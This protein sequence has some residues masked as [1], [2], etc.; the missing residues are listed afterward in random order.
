MK[1]NKILE[2]KFLIIPF[3]IFMFLLLVFENLYVFLVWF[4]LLLLLY[5]F[6]AFRYKN[7]SF[8]TL[9]VFTASLV[10]SAYIYFVFSIYHKYD[11][12]QK[13]F[14]TKKF[15]IN[16]KLVWDRYVWKDEFWNYFILKNLAKNYEIWEKLKIYGMLYPVE[17]EQKSYKDFLTKRFL[18]TNISFEKLKNIFQFDYKNYLLMKDILW[19][20][21]SK[22]EFV[23]WKEKLS[24][25][26][27]LRQDLVKKY[28]YIYSWYDDKY[29]ALSLGLLIWDKSYLDKKLYDDFIHSGLVHIIVVS[30]WN[31]MFLII[32]LSI[33]LFFIPFYVRLFVIAW[34]IV[35]YA[36]V[37]WWDS[38]VIRAT[39]MW[40]LSL[41]ALF[42]WKVADVRRFLA[43]AFVIM[44]VYNPY[45]LLYDLGFILSF[46]AIV[47][48]L[49]FNK[50][51]LKKD[52]QKPIKSKFIYFYNNYV[53]PTLWASLF[54]APAILLFTN[55][56]NILAFIASIFV[57]PIVPILMLNSFILL[58]LP[59][60]LLDFFLH[61]NIFLMDYIF[62]FVKLFSSTFTIFIKI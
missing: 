18:S 46:L 4:I 23:I 53:L 13:I 8:L 28:D 32:F 22:K 61:I 15:T 2:V 1:E 10:L 47:W 14:V 19:T 50:F 12:Y 33:L 41:I 27:Q 20:V 54:T 42:F 59:H 52:D 11:W 21:Y 36:F 58:F 62:F 35:F 3:F 48:I 7:I 37:V 49:V 38:S 45:F 55:Q 31:I 43:F 56:V 60:F 57:V 29:K 26:R 51:S 39:I 44:L 24:L 40:I 17:L 16:E 34:W 6:L 9:L 25:S 5:I 30:W